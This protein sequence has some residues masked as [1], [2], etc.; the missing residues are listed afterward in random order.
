MDSQDIIAGE[1]YVVRRPPTSAS[2]YLIQWEGMIATV[3][4]LVHPAYSSKSFVVNVSVETPT[5]PVRVQLFP[6]ELEEIPAAV[7]A[8]VL[9][10]AVLRFEDS[11]WYDGTRVQILGQEKVFG[12]DVVYR[13]QLPNGALV[14][15]MGRD[16]SHTLGSDS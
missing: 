16:I 6:D 15:V 7:A 1:K 9:P 10:E 13:V 2:P 8:R 5:G 11:M 14:S 3:V 12:V 4:S